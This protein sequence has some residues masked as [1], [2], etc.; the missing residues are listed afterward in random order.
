[1]DSLYKYKGNYPQ[2]PSSTGIRLWHVDGRLLK[3]PYSSISQITT[4]PKINGYGTTHAMSNTYEDDDYGSPLGSSYHDYNILQLIRD[5]TGTT[6]YPSSDI[7]NTDLFT[8]GESFSMS[9]YSSQFVKG[10]NI[11]K[12]KALGWSFSV[13]ISGSGE[14]ATATINLV[15]S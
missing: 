1:M 7:S 14:S 12:G 4:N 10:T 5:N 15:R 2:G 6:Y 8:S 11:N 13:T 3:S 9:K